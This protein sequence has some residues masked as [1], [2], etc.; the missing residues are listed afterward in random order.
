MSDVTISQFAEV[1]KVPVDR[2]LVQLDE[3]GIEN[4]GPDA[5]I[6]DDAKMELL[7]YLRR[8]HG[9]VGESTKVTPKKIT[10]QR[11]SQSELRLS[12][13]QGRSRMVNVE[14]RKKRTYVNRGALE[15][16]ARKEQEAIDQQRAAE[17]QERL[18]QERAL[19]AEREAREAEV[20]RI[21]DEEEEKK[22][23]A[24][25]ARL[26]EEQRRQDEEK[27]RQRLEQ[28][29]TVGAELQK[30]EQPKVK[31]DA[32][33]GR[34]K[35]KSDDARG[36][37][38]DK[39]VDKSTRYGRK[40]LHVSSTRRKKR[41]S[42]R[43]PVST[44]TVDAQHGFEMP[45]AP[46]I[47]NVE[48]PESISVG[49]LAQQMAIK[50]SEVIRAMMNLGVMATINQVIDQDTAV[51]VVEEMGHTAKP[52]KDTGIEAEILGSV[53]TSGDQ[54]ARPPVVTIMGHVD[55][56]KTSL[57]DYIRSTKVTAGE[58]GGITQHIGAYHVETA[59]A[60]I[61][62]LDTPGHAAFTA[63]RA[64]GAQA[65]DI[66]I[67]VVAA[68]DGVKPQTEEAIEHAKAAGVPMVVAVNKID[69]PEADPDRVRNELVAKEVVPDD[70]GGDTLFVNVSAQTGEGID[71]LLEA[72]ALQA[73]LQDLKAVG[74]GLAAGV[75]I[76]STL[77]K[78][79]GAV[80]T[81]LVTRGRLNRGD[82]IVAGEVFGRVRNMLDDTGERV[83]SAGPSMP[84]QVLGLAGTPEAG[85]DVL[86]LEDERKVRELAEFRHSKARDA[87]LAKQQAA[88]LDDVFSQMQSTDTQSVQIMIKADA[89]GSTE[90]IR[91]ALE[92]LS[93][94]EVQ[95]K[96]IASG[97]GGI[98]ESDVNLAAASKAI[99]I[100]FNVRA[101]AS[102]R[103]VLKET[104]VDIRYY[105]IIYE[106]IDD[107]K[108]AITGLLQP[109]V[110]EE[111]VGLAEVKDVFK[112]PK[113]GNIAGC[114]V[115]DGYVKKANPIRVLRD[116]VVIYEGEL[117]SLRRFKDDVNEVRAGTEC[118]I[119]VK[120]YNDVKSG[121]QIE[122]YER[123]EVAREL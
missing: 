90:A 112:S 97:V 100:G 47:H 64:R 52:I 36:K 30:G 117:E 82:S 29:A 44:V 39:K 102:A 72:V 56:G 98:T 96:V 37:K 81:I 75:V 57:L 67:L 22:K 15:D 80:A 122:C 87:K 108:L 14:V 94:E 27:E 76:E 107:V 18:E 40:E 19:E 65:T 106:A 9:R 6:T 10:L 120:N 16:D 71:K 118:G 32:P 24:E 1:L 7:T 121:D 73:E 12:G 55:H 25:Q 49:D 58:A 68:D 60:A 91:D 13:T 110:R 5:I 53:A 93:H 111:I 31:S 88:K 84:V 99:I 4:G 101:D 45:T 8:S 69:R 89:H 95:V 86:A 51:L 104:G 77:E 119:G 43:R 59:N 85:D 11:R 79:R 105:S 103:T 41:K 66:V 34:G 35:A 70:W 3:A 21:K 123:V 28:A 46:V 50:A 116:N 33:A 83:E 23:A 2:L 62:F 92:K 26:I 74:A 42:R 114:L 17:I 20:Q 48:I 78:G 38:G 109:E 63:M 54:V 115:V 113:L 61:T